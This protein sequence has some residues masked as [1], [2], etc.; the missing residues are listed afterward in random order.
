MAEIGPADTHLKLLLLGALGPLGGSTSLGCHVP[1]CESTSLKSG[2]SN[3]AHTTLWQQL[4]VTQL[5]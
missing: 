2:D 1:I 5:H 3:P 4:L